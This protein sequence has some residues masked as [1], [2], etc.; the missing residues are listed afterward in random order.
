VSPEVEFMINCQLRADCQETGINSV[1]NAR[2]RVWT[3]LFYF[4]HWQC[5]SC[6]N[7]ENTNAL[8]FS[9][10]AHT[11]HNYQMRC[12]RRCLLQ[13]VGLKQAR[14]RTPERSRTILSNV[15]ACVC[16]RL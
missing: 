1:P 7:L 3:T 5:L 10:A 9:A 2:D 11:V 14:T 8:G 15:S 12:S 13:N 4:R 16:L 6:T